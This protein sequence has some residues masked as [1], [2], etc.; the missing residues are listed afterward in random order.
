MEALPI[1]E[2]LREESDCAICL[3]EFQ[4]EDKPKRMP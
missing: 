1:V 3:L 4:V 2:I